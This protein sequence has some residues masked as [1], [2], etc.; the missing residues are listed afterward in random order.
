MNLSDESKNNISNIY[1]PKSS[2][3][4]VYIP[5]TKQQIFGSGMA[6]VR[7][8]PN[9]GVVK[10]VHLKGYGSFSGRGIPAPPSRKI[11]INV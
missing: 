2:S 7:Y 5:Q 10:Q 6:S 3:E 1:M 8:G 9:T 11:A 4:F